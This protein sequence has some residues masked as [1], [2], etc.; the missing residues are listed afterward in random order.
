[1]VTD[2]QLERLLRFDG[3]DTAERVTGKDYKS[4]EQTSFLGMALSM[5]NGEAK[6]TTLA[7]LGD[8]TGF[9][10][11]ERYVSVIEGAGYQRVLDE[12]FVDAYGVAQTYFI[13]AHPDGLLLA[14]DSYGE[15]LNGGKVYYNWIPADRTI[16]RLTSSGAYQSTN[17]DKTVMEA[18]ADELVWAGD[19][20]CREALLFNM[21]RLRE[22]GALLTRWVH[23]PFLWLKHHGEGR[24]YK[25]AN[26]ACIAALPEWVRDMVGADAAISKLGEA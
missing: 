14:F 15:S 22:N 9:D 17:P 3:L 1:M 12:P 11:M 25:E 21:R 10:T 8:T 26:A 4:D 6:R 2:R 5:S 18:A 23:R 20:D 7:E 24:D 13:Y 19:H 16:G